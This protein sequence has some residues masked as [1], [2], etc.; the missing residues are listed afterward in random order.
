MFG[1]LRQ[2]I[3]SRGEASGAKRQLGAEP[4]TLSSMRRQRAST[5]DYGGANLGGEPEPWLIGGVPHSADARDVRTDISRLLY[6]QLDMVS[7]QDDVH[8]IEALIR[9]VST[10]DLDFPPFPKIAQQL[11]M[12]LSRPE[13]DMSAVIRLVEQDPDL[14]RRVWQ[15]ANSAHFTQSPSSLHQAIT[16]I[17]FDDLWRIGMQVCMQSGVFRAKGYEDAANNVRIHGFVVAELCALLGEDQ[18]GDYF[19]SGLLHDIGKL[20]IYRAAGSIAPRWTPDSSLVKRLAAELHPGLG[21]L[22]MRAWGLTDAVCNAVGFH[23]GPESAPSGNQSICRFLWLSDV[24]AHT[25]LATLSERRSG[26]HAVLHSSKDLNI[27]PD[28]FVRLAARWYQDMLQ[29]H[30]LSPGVTLAS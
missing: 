26:G 9:G 11:D 22:L 7:T 3:F 15:K 16:R 23:H 4:G 6:R 19:L 29:E 17:G 30:Q 24:A 1:W 21:F 2:R 27:E 20:V 14:V 12:L 25:A 13:P 18:R 28:E 10:A 8:F 5:M